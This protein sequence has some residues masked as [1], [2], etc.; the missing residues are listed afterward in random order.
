M[1]R[2]ECRAFSLPS[3]DS[4]TVGATCR[5]WVPSSFHGHEVDT[6]D[7][8]PAKIKSRPQVFAHAFRWLL[9]RGC[10]LRSV[11]IHPGAPTHAT[12]PEIEGGP[13]SRLELSRSRLI[14]F[15]AE[16]LDYR[17]KASER[18]LGPERAD[19]V[20]GLRLLRSPDD[21]QT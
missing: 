16:A 12:T 15:V 2:R 9:G 13:I 8:R 14:F 3:R 11:M 10:D 5:S 21:V 19:P 17:I 18:K 20:G 1:N 4:G 6:G 7:G